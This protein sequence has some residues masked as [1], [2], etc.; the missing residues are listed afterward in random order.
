M[1]AGNALDFTLPYSGGSEYFEIFKPSTGEEE[2]ETHYDYLDCYLT[3]AIEKDKDKEQYVLNFKKEGAAKAKTAPTTPAKKPPGSNKRIATSSGEDWTSSD[4]DES[5][6][7]SEEERRRARKAHQEKPSSKQKSSP[8]Q[9][10]KTTNNNNQSP[11]KSTK[12]FW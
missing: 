2:S 11:S 1:E 4:D 7:D 9:Q 10:K 12:K 3:K 6:T 8:S 5:S